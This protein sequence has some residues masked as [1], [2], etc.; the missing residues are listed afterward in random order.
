[1]AREN[2]R[3]LLLV[4]LSDLPR[5]K[6][7]TKKVKLPWKTDHALFEKPATTF[8]FASRVLCSA[9]FST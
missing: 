5:S 8:K 1:M 2:G 6:R 3:D 7:D 4:D 9:I